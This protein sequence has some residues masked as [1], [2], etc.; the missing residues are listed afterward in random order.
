VRRVLSCIAALLCASSSAAQSPRDPAEL[1]A[2]LVRQQLQARDIAGAVVAVVRDGGAPVWVQAF[3]TADVATARPMTTDTRVRLASISKVFTTVAVMQ[4]VDKGAL[5]LDQDIDA[6]IDFRIPPSTDARPT[7]LRRLLSHQDG[8]E[9]TLIGIASV[10]GPRQPLAGYLP[11]HLPARPRSVDGV[12]YSN[13][14]F[15]VVAY[16]VE[17]VSGYTFEEY[18]NRFVFEPLQM[19]ETTAQQPVPAAWLPSTSSGYDR[20]S[21]L[22]TA[23]SMAAFTVHE[24]GSTGVVSTAR[25]MARF[26][27]ALLD[28]PAGFL[29]ARA[30]EAMRQPQVHTPR[31][32]VALTLYSPLATGGNAFIGH[33]G[34]SGGFHGSLAFARD[35]HFAVF[36]SYNSA[37]VPQSDTPEGELLR[38]LSAAYP[39]TSESP[40]RQAIGDVSGVYEPVRRIYSNLF[41]LDA[42]FG[43]LRIR[44]TP[45][46][47]L[48]NFAFVPIGGR[49]L[50]EMSP[51]E[52]IGRGMA[53]SFAASSTGMQAQLGAPVA[54]YRRVRWWSSAQTIVPLV[55]VSLAVTFVSTS[56][57]AWRLLKR[58]PSGSVPGRLSLVLNGCAILGALW[59][60]TAGR[61]VAA[62]AS[63]VLT[64]VLL[65]IYAAAWSAAC[66]AAVA[67]FQCLRRPSRCRWQDVVIA[68]LAVLTSAVCIA[69]RIAGTSLS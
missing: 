19:T 54:S 3:G 23:R 40:S 17:R 21:A 69:W 20:A 9:D 22:P 12:A 6:Y 43:Q 31:G 42:L 32:F 26:M 38:T 58:R 50:D 33:D 16:V 4:L 64:V 11:R 13:Y 7:T 44:K 67:A 30:I 10:G 15:A 29:S 47:I 41:A 46:G 18:L 59:L 34:G 5:D 60:I 35:R 37:G 63:P 53:M 61:V 56:R 45:E 1:I 48:I 66:L 62:T 36:V 52:F 68:I 65:A 8:F 14:A 25:D 27:S 49:Q 28:P 51:A 57:G 55:V 39:E 24:A 2:P